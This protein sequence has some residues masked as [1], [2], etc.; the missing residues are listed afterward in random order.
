MKNVAALFS[1]HLLMIVVSVLALAGCRPVS[2]LETFVQ[3][4]PR[5]EYQDFLTSKIVSDDTFNIKTL[6]SALIVKALFYGQ[7]V[8]ARA[9][10]LFHS[11]PIFS[12]ET[13]DW[14]RTP[15]GAYG[16]PVVILMGLFAPDLGEKDVTKLGRFRPK[17]RTMDGRVLSP[18]SI[19][20]FGRDSTFVRD[21]FP[22]FN[23][24][25]EVFLVKFNP[26]TSR[27][28]YTSRLEF[29]LEWPGG[30]QTLILNE[31]AEAN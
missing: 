29:I 17:L 20:R 25:E 18:T 26:L 12:K 31:N 2:S 14:G 19:K 30:V 5:E 13:S 3:P 28:Y 6:S 23:P 9:R 21:Y 7:D 15:K 1:G 4:T 27:G 11:D 24:W 8:D 10:L 16:P 22:A